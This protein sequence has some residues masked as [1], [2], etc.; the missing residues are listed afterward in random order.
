MTP[1]LENLWLG[2]RYFLLFPIFSLLPI[3][4]PYVLSRYLSLLEYRYHSTRR[5]SIRNAMAQFLRAGPL[6]DEELDLA[7]RRYFEVIF[8]DEMDLFTYLFGSSKR[9]TR[10]MKI[11]G[12][13]HLEEALRKD[14]GGILLSAH[15]GAGF[16]ILP[17][18]KEK[19]I[20]AH[21][22]SADIEKRHHPSGKAL[23][24]YQRL[25][26]GAVKRAS[27]ERTL[28][29]KEGRQELIEALHERKWV[30]ILFDVPPFRVRDVMEVPFLSQKALFPKG[31]ISIAKETHVPILPFFSFLDGERKRRILFERSFF[32]EDIEG[33]VKTCVNLIETNIV[34]RPDHWHLWSVAHQ[35]F[36]PP[37]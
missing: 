18:L 11:E 14:R 23:Y 34:K 27:G 35:F 10:R 36:V 5:E 1:W 8:C 30:I 13:E 26:I 4:L 32:T 17:F 22:F 15:F 21:F 20:P 19:G 37:G 6:S 12:E 28:Y 16:W 3:P 7:A 33:S 9:L 2:L 29:K 25:R 24:Y 31:I